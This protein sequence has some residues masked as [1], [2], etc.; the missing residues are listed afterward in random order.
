VSRYRLRFLLQ[1]I[2]LPQG[3]TL[4]GRSASCHV[5]IEDPLVSRQHAR[6]V[7]E[8]A[9][10]T[11]EDLGSRN[12][13]LLNGRPAQ[14]L[15]EL[16]DGDRLRIGTQELVFCLVRAASRPGA[17]AGTRPTG[18]MCHCAACG[19]PYPM[20]SPQCPSCGSRERMDEDTVSGVV[21]DPN[22]N[23]T[24]EL[25]VE[26]LQRATSLERWDDAERVLRRSHANIEERV[27][28]GQPVSREHLDQIAEAAAR[29]A[30]ERQSAEWGNWLLGV[31]AALG[32]VPHPSISERLSTL[33]P[34][35][36]ASLAPAAHRVVESVN[37][38]GGPSEE[39]RAGF[40]RVESLTAPGTGGSG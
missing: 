13:L 10:A 17:T 11:A 20:E 32:M 5:T 39:D 14:G 26:V 33:P 7:I 15:T 8:G 37:A 6:I 1:E 34:A 16:K 3:E 18:F 4:I 19:L 24:L 23:W 29:V 2:D 35:E 30:E 12:G 9:R 38:R 25:L 31:Y 40:S 28:G 36:R 27:K 21:G 22:R